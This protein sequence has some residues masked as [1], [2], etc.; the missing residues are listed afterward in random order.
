MPRDVYTGIFITLVFKIEKKIRNYLISSTRRLLNKVWYPFNEILYHYYG[1]NIRFHDIEKY[2][3]TQQD[4]INEKSRFHMPYN[5]ILFVITKL[6]NVFGGSTRTEAVTHC[7][8]KCLASESGS[9]N[10]ESLFKHSSICICRGK[11]GKGC[12]DTATATNQAALGGGITQ[13]FVFPSHL[14][15][16]QH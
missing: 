12:T 16:S 4:V 8:K 10:P 15:V 1:N 11:S 9:P 5:M 14:S 3:N 6:V 7:L 2:Y 13:G